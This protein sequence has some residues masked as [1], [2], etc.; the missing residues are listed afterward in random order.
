MR[1]FVRLLPVISLLL[2]GTPHVSAQ[3]P[4]TSTAAAEA[5]VRAAIRQYDEVLKRA[6]VA[7][8]ERFWAEEYTFVNPQGERHSRADRIRNLRTGQTAV[9]SITHVPQEEQIR[10]Y[11]DVA[12]YTALMTISGQYAGKV[13]KGNDRILSIWTRRDGRWQQIATQMTSVAGQ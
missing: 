12:V 1:S 3:K 6:D 13:E 8:A 10:I 11:G 7:A 2:I 9:A 4:A 5:E